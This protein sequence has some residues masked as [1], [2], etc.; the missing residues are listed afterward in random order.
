MDA[1]R[2]GLGANKAIRDAHTVHLSPFRE[3]SRV[4]R[5]APRANH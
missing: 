4:A 3:A 2:L 1:Q 5:P